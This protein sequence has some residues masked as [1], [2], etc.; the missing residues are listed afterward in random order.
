MVWVAGN[1]FGTFENL[2]HRLHGSGSL[3]ASV[4][5]GHNCFCNGSFQ[6]RAS[7]GHDAVTPIVW[8]DRVAHGDD[9]MKGDPNG[10]LRQ[11]F[12]V[13]VLR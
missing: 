3:D 13:G 11:R 4:R 6:M 7:I 12:K 10:T 9:G 1:S 2:Q 5:I 8:I